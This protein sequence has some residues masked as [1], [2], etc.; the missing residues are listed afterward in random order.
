MAARLKTAI[1]WPH[2]HGH[3]CLSFSLSNQHC[4]D[5]NAFTALNYKLPILSGSSNDNESL[6]VFMCSFPLL[7]ISVHTLYSIKC[8]INT[9]I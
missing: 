3:I 2:V 5:K 8:Q 6:D 7:G 9:D 1:I 4:S